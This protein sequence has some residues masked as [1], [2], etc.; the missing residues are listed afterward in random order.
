MILA[1]HLQQVHFRLLL[2]SEARLMG[3][4]IP[5]VLQTCYMPGRCSEGGGSGGGTYLSALV[6]HFLGTSELIWI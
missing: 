4:D 2:F 1:K 5:V 3:K 6:R